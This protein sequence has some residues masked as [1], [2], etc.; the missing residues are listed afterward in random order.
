MWLMKMAARHLVLY[1]SG[2]SVD[3]GTDIPGHEGPPRRTKLDHSGNQKISERHKDGLCRSEDRKSPEHHRPAANHCNRPELIW[4]QQKAV[5]R[6]TCLQLAAGL[7]NAKF[8]PGGQQDLTQDDL[9]KF[10]N[11]VAAAV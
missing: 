9:L 10:G 1:Y 8:R 2:G 11:R 5:M 7:L 6:S 3:S 4:L